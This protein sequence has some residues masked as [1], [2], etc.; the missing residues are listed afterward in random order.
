VR[1][2]IPALIVLAALGGAALTG[3]SASTQASAC[4][5][6]S[7][8]GSDSITATGA[9]GKA[10]K[11]KVPSPLTVKKTQSSTLIE[12]NGR[13]V[14]KGGVAKLSITLYDATSGAAGQTQSGY[15][16]ISADQIGKGLT[17]ALTCAQQGSRIAV[18]VSPKDGATTLGA[19]EGGTAVA[20]VDV[21]SALPGR[22][23]GH[24]RPKTPGFPAVV[25]A[26]NGQP[27][28]VIGDDAA[29]T[30]VD[31]AVLKQGDGRKTKKSDTLIVQSQTVTWADKTTATGTWEQGSPATQSLNDGSAL[32]KELIGKTVGSQV[33]VLVPKSKSTDGEASVTV[34]DILGVLP[35]E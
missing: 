16:P 8:S 24:S 35:A 34:V 10:P 9:F 5:V 14:A 2:S 3:C 7:G 30:K 13:Q 17:N 15:F 4:S 28:I 1:R 26:P 27:G 19:A 11:A 29:P 31:S 12:G 21:E 20:V 32:S 23:T 18:V 25:L 22:A 6:T 33:E